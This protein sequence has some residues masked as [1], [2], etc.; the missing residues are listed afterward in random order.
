MRN[1]TT[2]K[3]FEMFPAISWTRILTGLCKGWEPRPE[4]F[5]SRIPMKIVLF[6]LRPHKPLA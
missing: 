6:N 1:D 5:L 3:V 4:D 2:V